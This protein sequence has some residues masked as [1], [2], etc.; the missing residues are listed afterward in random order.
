MEGAQAAGTGEG[1]QI[2]VE[3]APVSMGR[4]AQ[5]TQAGDHRFFAGWRSDPFFFD[6][7]GALNNFQFTGEDFFADKDVCSI[8][9][10]VPNS[11]L[12]PK[13]DGPVGSHADRAWA[14]DGFRRI[15]ARALANAFLTGEQNA[16]YRAAEP[17]NDAR[18]VAVFAH[19][20]EHTGGYTPEEAS[21]VAGT[22]AAGPSAL[23][24]YASSILSEQRPDAH[25]RRL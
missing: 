16:D 24:P 11:V 22:T 14:G 8:A 6:T 20:L 3:G 5:V 2:I 10:E 23:R 4:E 25:R 12:G 17:A 19:S 15:A 1:G 9:L 13:R 18:F 21:R 7:R